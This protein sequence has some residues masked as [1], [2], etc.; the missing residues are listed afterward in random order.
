MSARRGLTATAACAPRTRWGFNSFATAEGAR[1]CAAS[2]GRNG[3]VWYIW[4]LADGT[5][6]QSAVPNPQSPGHPAELA[7]V[8]ELHGPPSRRKVVSRGITREDGDG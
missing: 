1:R 5:F 2:L 6:I 4:R 8:I 7:E 3:S